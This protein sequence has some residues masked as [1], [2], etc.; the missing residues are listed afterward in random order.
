VVDSTK[1]LYK[2]MINT[3]FIEQHLPKNEYQNSI[4]AG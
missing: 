2:Q 4:N 1:K 3:G